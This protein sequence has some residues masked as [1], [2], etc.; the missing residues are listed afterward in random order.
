MYCIVVEVTPPCVCSWGVLNR[1][2]VTAVLNEI[3]AP[4]E[5]WQVAVG[6]AAVALLVA[7][8]VRW[9]RGGYSKN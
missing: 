9:A 8:A 6:S 1:K 3:L 5:A 4:F 7:H 2:M